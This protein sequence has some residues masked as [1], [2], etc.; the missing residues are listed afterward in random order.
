[1]SREV[2]SA[3][4]P[5]RD[6]LPTVSIV[7]LVYNRREELRVSLE[8][9]LIDGDYER[10]RIDVIVVDNASEDGASEMIRAEYPD[11]RLIRREQNNGVSGFNDGF[12]VADGDY[13]LALDDDCYLPPDGLRRAVEAARERD[14]SLVSFG[15]TSPADPSY[16]F[17]HRYR[18]GLLTF[19]GCA[20]L[21][22]RDALQA[23]GGYDPEIFVW[24]NELEFTLR[25]FDRGYRHLHLPEVV[26]IH[27][28]KPT[29]HWL[30]LFDAPEYVVNQRHFAYIAA[31]LMR[32]RDALGVLVALITASLRDT[33][34]WR[35]KA[36]AG[37]VPALRGFAHGLVH[38]APL[39][40]SEISAT[41]RQ[42]FHSFLSPWWI[43]RPPRDFVLIPARRAIA[44]LSGRKGPASPP[45]RRQEY[46][47]SRSRYYPDSASTLEF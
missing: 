22:R 14:A 3:E 21:I 15:V 31:K 40:N 30:E 4:A 39:A 18:T 28:K 26:A 1:M 34:R 24:A 7:F 13:V 12:A 10:S 5:E 17:D 32:P 20:V 36:V 6:P 44:R 19:W 33:V 37:V 27:M 25:F 45:G 23:L 38:R 47:E 29:G 8:K 11:V 35:R 46:F 9:M 2:R 16:R 41:Y 43:A 42:N